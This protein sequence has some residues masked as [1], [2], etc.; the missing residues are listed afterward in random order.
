MHS[1]LHRVRRFIAFIIGITFFVSG[2]LKLMDP[3]GSGL[4]V[5][6]YLDFMHLG[7]LKFGSKA[8]GIIFAA[9]ETFLGAAL[10]SGV[11]RKIAAIAIL[12]LQC[13]FTILTLALVIFQPNTDCGCFGEAIELTHTE[14]LG[15]NIFLLALMCGALLPFSR[16]GKPKKRKYISFYIVVL[17]SSAFAIYSGLFI[18]MIDYTDFRPSTELSVVADDD[19]KEE[20]TATFIYEKDGVQ[21]EFTLSELPDS[22]W[23]YVS[24]KTEQ[25]EVEEDNGINDL[26]VYNK[27]GEY[28]DSIMAEGK[29]MVV[30]IYEPDLR[31][32]QL[33]RIIELTDDT[34]ENDFQ[35]IILSSEEDDFLEE[36]FDSLLY[37]DRKTLMTLNRSNGG[38]TL[39]D[40]GVLIRKWANRALPNEEEI[41][42]YS[43][44][45][46]RE[47][48]LERSTNT[49]LAFQGFFLFVFAVLLLL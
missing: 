20:Y 7:F 5:D 27:E 12:T 37:S 1:F 10:M 47:I 6:S 11:Y 35:T 28:K 17:V 31:D 33:E 23:K 44:Q 14:T 19:D 26:S 34:M 24:T 22:T 41:R 38:V 15:K 9:I 48:E 30:S 32:K 3:V 25:K 2:I 13:F 39:F 42:E 43:E 29:I 36:K 40:D 46:S 16:L 4:I 49:H 8:F 21:E 45:E 18:P